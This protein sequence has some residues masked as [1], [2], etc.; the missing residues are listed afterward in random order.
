MFALTACGRIAPDGGNDGATD[1]RV[2][3][4]GDASFD[5]GLE[6]GPCGSLNGYQACCDGQLCNGKC[7]ADGGCECYGIKGGCK[8]PLLCCNSPGCTAALFCP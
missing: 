5:T 8:A 2:E 4:G 3:G 6:A 1:V 7:G